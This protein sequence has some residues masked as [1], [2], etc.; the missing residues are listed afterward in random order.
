MN[1]L[2]PSLRN[3]VMGITSG[4]IIVLVAWLVAED[5]P[6]FFA[7][8]RSW[9]VPAILIGALATPVLMNPHVR[10]KLVRPPISRPLTFAALPIFLLPFVLA[11]IF[12]SKTDLLPSRVANFL[13]SNG[14]F[15]LP[16]SYVYKIRPDGIQA[17]LQ[18]A[19]HVWDV[20][21]WVA[22]SIS[23]G[24]YFQR[25]RIWY[26]FAIA[27]ICIGLIVFAFN[28]V[29]WKLGYILWSLPFRV[30]S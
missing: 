28:F 29:M 23:Y 18:P 10:P 25:I 4:V 12:E 16:L 19:T 2:S 5:A 1:K 6:S 27:P 20:L 9:G 7:F 14:R 13:F 22:A 30:V 15:V 8:L 11:V 3:V 21:F 17:I 26:A 24:F